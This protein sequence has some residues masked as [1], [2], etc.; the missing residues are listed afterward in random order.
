M[1]NIFF[2]IKQ[3]EDVLFDLNQAGDK[4]PEV[5]KAAEDECIKLYAERDGMEPLER[6]KHNQ[7]FA[8]SE[9][10]KQAQ[11]DNNEF[12]GKVQAQLQSALRSV[13]ALPEADQYFSSEQFFQTPDGSVGART[14]D[15]GFCSILELVR[16]E[17]PASLRQGRSGGGSIEDKIAD[18]EDQLAQQQQVEQDWRRRC[19]ETRADNAHVSRWGQE[20]DKTKDLRGQ[21]EQLK[22]QR[23]QRLQGAPAPRRVDPVAVRNLEDARTE[24]RR[25]EQQVRSTGRAPTDHEMVQVTQAR[26]KVRELEQQA[27]V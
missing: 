18:L 16:N 15:G 10:H 22:E 11:A 4:A 1:D 17:L 8:G 9:Q 27:G 2:R 20:R 5:I 13:G 19:Q 14:R 24:L 23:R 26:R 6:E 3:A 21:L 12:H 7:A 25:I